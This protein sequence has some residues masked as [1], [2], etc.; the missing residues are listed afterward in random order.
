MHGKL[1]R[2]WGRSVATAMVAVLVTLAMSATVNLARAATRQP[3]DCVLN[4][5]CGLED[6]N[7]WTMNQRLQFVRSLE[8]GPASYF[9]AGFQRWYA[10]EGILEFFRDHS[11]GA[12]GS[13]IS[14]TDAGILMGIERGTALALGLPGN[15]ALDS[16]GAYGWR[17]YL[18]DL[19]AGTGNL[20]D[21]ATHDLRWS[22]AEQTAT[23]YGSSY[24]QSKGLS[25]SSFENIWYQWSQAWRWILRNEGT[26]LTWLDAVDQVLPGVGKAAK[27]VL[28]SAVTDVNSATSAYF[29]ANFTWYASETG[30]AIVAII[31]AFAN[32]PNLSAAEALAEALVHPCSPCSGGGDNPSTFPAVYNV[33]TGGAFRT[34][35][36]SSGGASG[37]LGAPSGNWTS[38]AGGQQQRFAG[39]AIEWSSTTGT[40]EVHG[41]IYSHYAALGGPSG[42]LSFPTTN[43]FDAPG[44]GRQ[45]WFSGS[46]CGAGSV[47]LWSTATGAHEMHGCIY[48][49]FVRKWGGPGGS[50][51]Y[52]T[53]DEVNAPQ[54]S[55]S[56][57]VSYM[58]GTTCGASRGSALYWTASK[59]TWPVFGCIYQKFRQLGETASPLGFPVSTEYATSQGTRQD[60]TGGY[61]IWA[62]GVA[63][64]HY[65]GCVNY[66]AYATGPS[67]CSGFS[68]HS[69][70][71]DGGGVGLL[72]KEIWTY[73]NGTVKDSTATYQ[74]SGM[75]SVH[76]WQLQAYIP[77]NH[78]NASH[79]HYHYCS[80]G[81]GCADGYVNQ[82]NYT[83]QWASFGAVCTSDGTATIVLADDGGD[84]Y[85]AQVG[86]DAIRA[87]RQSIVC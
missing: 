13:W 5:D 16:G 37:F 62:N 32:A 68:T 18:I 87:V 31:Q 26:I 27:T 38:V 1:G 82:N 59:G 43:E 46:S 45:N 75:D 53:S 36:N 9:H 28:L 21:R 78:S 14:Y 74:L 22:T 10:V 69:T 39:G 11:L 84:A 72:G 80:P 64:P 57:R 58:Y 63:T 41:A 47:I 51:N 70:W 23:D 60:F 85:P 76:L 19:R 79:A 83:N 24:A 56:G 2:R 66:G 49:D 12:P 15:A 3:A 4:L 54:G 48:A 6:F 81:G 50:F 40:Y 34:V 67:A 73:A 30:V 20:S 71:F 55:L 35:W 25:P 7:L 42:L 61:I 33:P 65:Y 44:G 86:A 29:W 77:N 8:V 52:P 17:D